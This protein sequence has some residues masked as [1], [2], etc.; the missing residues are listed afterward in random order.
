MSWFV[1]D[2]RTVTTLRRY[3][4]IAGSVICKRFSLSWNSVSEFSLGIR[5]G[6]RLPR[7]RRS[8][9]LSVTGRCGSRFVLLP[10]L[11]QSSGDLRAHA[12]GFPTSLRVST[13][14][15]T[16]VL[17]GD[18]RGRNKD[19]LHRWRRDRAGTSASD[20]RCG[21]TSASHVTRMPC[22]P[23]ATVSIIPIGTISIT[24]Y[25]HLGVR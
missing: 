22:V 3:S 18:Q 12:A 11:R 13:V 20:P 7:Y 21:R 16:N 5:Q 14:R 24:I 1:N 17:P 23:Y 9:T 25:A 15:S 4:S 10:S 8:S 19:S 2:G 6:R